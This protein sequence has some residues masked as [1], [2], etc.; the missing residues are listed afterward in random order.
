MNRLLRDSSRADG[1]E[2][3]GEP[4][5]EG[6]ESDPA[7][8]AH[9]QRPVRARVLASRGVLRSMKELQSPEKASGPQDPLF[10]EW[11]SEVPVEGSQGSL[12]P[13]LDQELDQAHRFALLGRLFRPISNFFRRTLVGSLLGS[14][15]SEDA[16][17]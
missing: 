2:G 17:S 12:A 9:P 10:T 1:I 16:S 11:S 8:V 4:V 3:A 14:N 13:S 7:A 5:S 15:R 6:S